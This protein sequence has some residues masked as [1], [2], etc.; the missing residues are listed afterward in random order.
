MPTT[1]S[2]SKLRILLVDDEPFIRRVTI[3]VLKSLG[4]VSVLEADNGVD[5][6]SLLGRN[7]VDLL[8]SDIQMP[9]MNGLELIQKIRIGETRADHALRTIVVTSFSYTEV[10]SSCL[11]LDVNGFLVK[12]INPA[13]VEEKIRFSLKETFNL[14]PAET[15]LQVKTDLAVIEAT[16]IKERRKPNAAI[17]RSGP[18]VEEGSVGS[19]VLLKQLQPGMVLLDDL[20]A[21]S[22]IR[23][24]PKGQVLTAVMINRIIDL[25]K[26]LPS[27]RLRVKQV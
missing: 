27:G 23:L 15:Y 9:E 4:V 1:V 20:Y 12:P 17:A 5:A 7:D 14:R 26:V 19:S 2:L 24:L 11:L 25:D 18:E 6:I 8:I 22:G 3:N 10:L 21:T 16:S 13:V